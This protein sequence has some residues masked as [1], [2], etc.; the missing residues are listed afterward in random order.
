MLA[1]G[2]DCFA[3]LAMTRGGVGLWV[4]SSPAVPRSDGRALDCFA[5][6]AMTSGF[7]IVDCF[8]ACGSSQ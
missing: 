7:R 5:A 3:V 1:K 6:L 8:G 4:A 2:E